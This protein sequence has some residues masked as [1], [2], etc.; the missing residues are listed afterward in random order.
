M[1]IVAEQ[2]LAEFSLEEVAARADVTRNLLYHYFPRGRED[3]V[4]AVAERAGRQLTDDW[5]VGDDLPLDQRLAANFARIAEHAM[6][7]TDAWR[8]HRRARAEL[9]PELAEI[10]ARFSDIVVSSVA[11]NH[12]GTRNPPPL[13]RLALL[14]YL[15]FAETVLDE[16]RTAG[17]PSERVMVILADTLVA[18]VRAAVAASGPA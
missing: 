5:V 16:A 4:L 14:G 3:I 13:V 2:G 6:E 1:P 11:L 9:E 15:A 8:I 10:V 18:T 12:V 17:E 7:P